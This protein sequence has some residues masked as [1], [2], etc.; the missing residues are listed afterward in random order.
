MTALATHKLL[1]STHV[2]PYGP[3]QCFE[4]TTTDVL[5]VNLAHDGGISDY[6]FTLARASFHTS[7]NAFKH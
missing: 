5:G 6:H 7:I 3:W 4:R 1:E 2:Y